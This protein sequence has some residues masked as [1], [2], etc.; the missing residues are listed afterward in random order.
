MKY[1]SHVA[2]FFGLIRL[3]LTVAMVAGAIQ[4]AAAPSNKQKSPSEMLE[5]QVD[6]LRA[7]AN[8]SEATVVAKELLSVRRQDPNSKAFQLADAERL[9]ATLE[10]IG[11]MTP[12][13]QGELATAYRQMAGSRAKRSRGDDKGAAEE[14][15]QALRTFRKY[16]GE[17]TVEAMTALDDVAV[18]E[19]AQAHYPPADSIYQL[20]LGLRESMLGPEHPDVGATL[21]NWAESRREQGDYKNAEP[22]YDRALKIAIDARGP[23]HAD[24]GAIENNLGMVY[25]ATNRLDKAVVIYK[26]S[27]AVREAALGPESSEVGETCNNLGI[28]YI[29]KAQYAD[30]EKVFLRALNIQAKRDNKKE[31][32]QIR[33]N[34]ASVYR[35]QGR[36][37]ESES[38]FLDAIAVGQRA[39]APDHPFVASF[40]SNFAGLR[41]AQGRYAEAELLYIKGWEMRKRTLPPDHPEIASSISNLAGLYRVQGRYAEAEPMYLKALAMRRKAA[42]ESREVAVGLNN[43]GRLYAAQGRNAEAEDLYRQAIAMWEKT[44]GPGHQDVAGGLNN[45]GQLLSAQGRYAEANENLLRALDLREKAAKGEN[46]LVAQSLN[47]LGISYLDERKFA[48]ALPL[49]QRALRIF[50]RLGSETPDVATTLTTL[51]SLRRF[52][53]DPQAAF[54][55]ATRAWQIRNAD[56]ARNG[57]VL[58]EVDALTYAERLQESVDQ[59]LSIYQDLRDHTPEMQRTVAGIVLSSKG[60]VSDNLYERRKSFRAEGDLTTLPLWQALVTTR[61]EKARV[62]NAGPKDGFERYHAKMDSLA[63]LEKNLETDLARKSA[64]FRRDQDAKTV[65][66]KRIESLLPPQSALVEY[67]RYDYTKPE[68]RAALEPHYLALVIRAGTAPAIVDLGSAIAIEKTVSQYREHLAQVAAARQP[69][70]SSAQQA[71]YVSIGDAL[72]KQGWGPVRPSLGDAKTLLIAP[73]GA[74]NLVSF[75]GLRDSESGEYLIEEQAVHY[76]S[77]GRDLIRYQYPSPPAS[78]LLALG[79]PD[80]GAPV[81]ARLYDRASSEDV[82]RGHS[83][84]VCVEFTK[85]SWQPL[86]G[87]ANE[88]KAVVASWKKEAKAPARSRLGVEASEERFKAEAHGSRVLHLA[89]HGYYLAGSCYQ[90]SAPTGPVDVRSPGENPLLLSGLVLA[91]ANLHGKG[92][93]VEGAEDGILTAYEVVAM[94]LEGTDMVVLS[95]C[96]TSLGT[97]EDGEGVYGLRRAFLMAGSEI[98]VSALWPVSDRST[99]SLMGRLYEGG[100]KP[101]YL[102]MQK[103]QVDRIKELRRKKAP[104]HPFSWGAFVVMGDIE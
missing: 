36:Y 54:I 89:T 68:P 64:T 55:D 24:V 7:V 62:F 71:E 103:L 51:A 61:F 14:V 101:A 58:V 19:A 26:Q 5:S 79:N 27:L 10:R 12:K 95:G 21:N 78:A 59:C 93:T 74:L 23:D 88:V 81:E 13:V 75:A 72:F 29:K 84:A 17:R 102:R 44:L 66:S 83:Q 86:P 104:D 94:D 43:L 65:T 42:P 98:V 3:G 22:M 96:E 60:L 25:D 41:R 35:S 76:L 6:S 18:L 52:Q 63:L 16:L 8:F 47:S 85:R 9:V 82:L 2:R 73:D 34:L 45:L 1:S 90:E 97:V 4:L 67:A 28:T 40:M 50:E 30:A 33:N 11:T 57:V 48:E 80:Y 91:G 56:F 100:D 99:A 37:G 39:F 49:F 32:A 38:N 46:A 92:A 77:A 69:I 20:T 87:S 15:G 31:I 53:G 70:P